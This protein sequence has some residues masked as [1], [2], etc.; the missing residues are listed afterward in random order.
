V[1]FVLQVRCTR[2]ADGE[3]E[4]DDGIVVIGL[5]ELQ[6]DLPSLPHDLPLLLFHPGAQETITAMDVADPSGMHQRRHRLHRRE[7]AHGQYA[8]L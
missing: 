7:V 6:E 1:H 3:L 2:L 5:G 4:F 8:F